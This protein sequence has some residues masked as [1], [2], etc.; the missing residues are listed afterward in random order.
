[1]LLHQRRRAAG[2][3]SPPIR[4]KASGDDLGGDDR[5]EMGGQSQMG[6]VDGNR[7][8]VVDEVVRARFKG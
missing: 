6:A 8:I 3:L 5:L 2:R 7:Q 4:S 1:M